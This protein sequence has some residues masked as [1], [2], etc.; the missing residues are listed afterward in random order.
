MQQSTETYVP[1]PIRAA[2]V[3]PR[4]HLNK[5]YLIHNKKSEHMILTN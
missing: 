3:N 4:L 2:Q 1:H 5:S